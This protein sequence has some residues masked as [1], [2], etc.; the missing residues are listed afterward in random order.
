MLIKCVDDVYVTET[1][2]VGG[3]GGGVGR[4][5]SPFRSKSTLSMYCSSNVVFSESIETELNH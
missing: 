2:G 1:F 5:E 3:G 4:F